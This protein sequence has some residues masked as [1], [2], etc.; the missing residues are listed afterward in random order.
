MTVNLRDCELETHDEGPPG[1]AFRARS[2]GKSVGAKATGCTVY[3]LDAG[4]ASWP[5]H[6]ELTDE[7]WLFVIEGELTVRTPDG[8]RSLRAG[9]VVCFPLGPTGAHAVTNPGSAVARFAM[10]SAGFTRGGGCVY[11]DEGKFLI[12]ADDYRHRG[13]LGEQVDYWDGV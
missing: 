8:E 6:F 2:L 7:E 4:H 10:I 13:R 5:Y 1:R 12:Y 3:E 11:P 9:D